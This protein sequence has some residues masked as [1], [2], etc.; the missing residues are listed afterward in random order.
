MI[1]RLE[2]MGLSAAPDLD[3]LKEQALVYAAAAR[4]RLAEGREKLR[5]SI[6]NEPAR[7]LAIALGVGV[8][9]GWLIKRR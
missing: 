4:E 8:V 7:A 9:L 5:E 1:D 6:V 3:V 2:K